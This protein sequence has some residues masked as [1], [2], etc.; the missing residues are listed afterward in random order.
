MAIWRASECATTVHRHGVTLL[1]LLVVMLILLMVTAAAIPM[2]APALQNRRMREAARLAS[3]YISGARARAI[4]S[5]RDVGV[6][7]ERFEGR[8][9]A[10]TLSYVDVP[11]PY[12]GD[13]TSSRMSVGKYR[14]NGTITGASNNG[15]GRIRITTATAIDSNIASG[16]GAYV[17]V[18]GVG[19][20][21]E[22]NGRWSLTLVDSTHFDLQ[23][24]IFTNT[25]TTGGTFTLY[26]PS[27]A[28][29][30]IGADSLWRN[31][32]RYGD[33]LQLDYR[34]PLYTIVSQRPPMP[35]TGDPKTG[36]TITVAPPGDTANGYWF[37]VDGNGLEVSVPE[38]YGNGVP[39]QIYRQ[40]VRSSAAPLQ[41]PESIVID[42]MYS[43]PGT[44]RWG[45]ITIPAAAWPTNPP[46]PF[47]P[48]IVFTPGG[49]V[50]YL[51]APTLA[52]PIAPIYLLLGR[53]ELMADV[54]KSGTDENINDNNPAPDTKNLYLENRWITIGYQTGLV[55]TSE[56]RANPPMS[57]ADVVKAREFAQSAQG[58][59]GQ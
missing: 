9:Y 53:R 31:L 48:V 4:Q 47:N 7:I 3:S 32:V 20:T 13:S 46:V 22:A 37:L 14:I 52:R 43:G 45:D 21:V 10:M 15:A 18:S 25:Y 49:S 24:S 42:L 50:S 34:G 51:G 35:A 55:T 2:M 6:M 36:Q 57:P 5:G 23:G 1:E 40:P 54:A 59:G 28:V 26:C 44:A 16:P 8:P 12:A 17:I 58:I 41:L 38:G 29:F 19:G 30:S 39:Y 11:L 33:R 56:V 27:C